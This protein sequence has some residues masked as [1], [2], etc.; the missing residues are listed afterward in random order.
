MKKIIA[1]LFAL[2]LCCAVLASS[3]LAM[4]SK[5]ALQSATAMPGEM[6]A[7]DVSIS[8]NPGIAYLKV[9]I[10]YDSEVLELQNATNTGLLKGIFT[11]SQTVAVKPYVL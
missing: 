5:I 4:D 9:E 6:I 8:G 11:T 1:C 7:L 10:C 2:V 3:A